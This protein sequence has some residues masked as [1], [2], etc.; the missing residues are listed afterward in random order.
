MWRLHCTGSNGS[1]DELMALARIG[2]YIR[3][4]SLMKSFVLINNYR[5]W[6]LIHRRKRIGTAQ[7]G[8]CFV[9]VGVLVAGFDRGFRGGFRSR[10]CA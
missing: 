7:L 2:R 5:S 1:I 10:I 3:H 8:G 6:D 9:G 4:I